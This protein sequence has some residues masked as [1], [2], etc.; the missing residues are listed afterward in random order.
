M[1]DG[2]WAIYL[3]KP[4]A[5]VPNE[6]KTT[7][8]YNINNLQRFLDVRFGRRPFEEIIKTSERSACNCHPYPYSIVFLLVHDMHRF[9][10][11][12]HAWWCASVAHRGFERS[13]AQ[14]NTFTRHIHST[15]AISPTFQIFVIRTISSE[16]GLR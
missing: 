16:S 12:A 2:I 4:Q 15:I 7:I 14:S 9:E 1:L 8:G 6:I 11:K 13:G 10:S 5:P 3:I